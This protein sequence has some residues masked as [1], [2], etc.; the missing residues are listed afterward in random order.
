[1]KTSTI[2]FF[3]QVYLVIFFTITLI[4]LSSSIFSKN[5][6]SMVSKRDIIVLGDSVFD[7]RSYVSTTSSIPYL[8]NEH[9]YLNAQV[10]AMDG[11][12]IENINKQLQQS[13]KAIDNNEQTLFISIGGN[14]ILTYKDSNSS[15]TKEEQKKITNF[16]DTIFGDYRNILKNYDF[17]CNIVLCNIYVP[18]NKKNS[19][20]EKCIHLWNTKL[21]AYAENNNYKVMKLDKLLY[22]KEDFAD[23]LEPS[24][25]GGEKIVKHMVSFIN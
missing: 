20:Y 14:N 6:E 18:Y 22:K 2:R 25:L 3:I 5:I 11:A 21:L 7:N 9:E 12:K 13:L 15:N 17:K 23:N 10:Y 4:R 8:L 1:M 24:K 19:V 16:V